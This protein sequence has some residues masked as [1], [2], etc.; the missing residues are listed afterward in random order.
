MPPAA[1]GGPTNA[2]SFSRTSFLFGLGEPLWA[3]LERPGGLRPMVE[4]EVSFGGI[5]LL[6]A[7]HLLSVTVLCCILASFFFSAIYVG[8]FVFKPYDPDSA[9]EQKPLVDK[10]G[11]EESEAERNWYFYCQTALLAALYCGIQAAWFN[12]NKVLMQLSW[13]SQTTEGT[14]VSSFPA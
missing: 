4:L 7:E 10:P 6:V 12:S 14:E 13:P 9:N 2:L 8:I 3:E 5:T 11:F 1:D